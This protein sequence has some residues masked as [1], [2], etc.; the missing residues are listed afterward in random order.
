M[1][2]LF[3]FLLILATTAP[4]WAQKLTPECEAKLQSV[5]QV[6]FVGAKIAT[7]KAGEYRT[8]MEPRLRELGVDLIY[9]EDPGPRDLERR[10]Q[11]DGFYLAPNQVIWTRPL[12][13]AQDYMAS[14][15][16]EQ[17]RRMKGKLKT[18]QERV[19]SELGPLTEADFAE[20]YALYDSEVVGRERGR[21]VIESTWAAEKG[22]ELQRYQRL[23]FRDN[24]SGELLGGVI[25]KVEQKTGQLQAPYG[26]YKH[27]ARDFNLSIRAFAESMDIGTARGLK[28]LS[29]GMD[30]NL[31]GHHLSI[32]LME[33]KSSLGF[34]PAPSRHRR[35]IKVLN[36]DKLNRDYFTFVYGQTGQLEG[37]HFADTPRGLTTPEGVPTVFHGLTP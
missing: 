12:M 28:R 22:S 6:N 17:R 35:F 36:P 21:R 3:T 32:G 31:Y 13:S 18:S 20:W 15:N 19:R 1:K 2:T 9:I 30:T 27:E 5:I 10:T 24:E 16:S 26:A 4:A 23:F 25:L 37:H 14:L 33:Y 29:Y 34:T 7:F 11:A 8:K